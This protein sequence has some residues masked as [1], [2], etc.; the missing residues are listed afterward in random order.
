MIL[1]ITLNPVV[2]MTFYVDELAPV[3]R[4]EARRTTHVAG[5]KGNNAARALIGLGHEVRALLPLGGA[6]GRHEAELLAQ[7]GIQ[8]AIAWTSGET[9]IVVTLIDKQHQMRAYFA[10]GAPFTADDAT[11]VRERFD[12][13][14]AENITAMCLCGSSPGPLADNLY[15]EFLKTAAARGIPTLLD[16]YG[17][18]LELSLQAP[19]TIVKVNHAEAETLLGRSLSTQSAQL[20]ALEVLRAGGARW[21]VLTLGEE[22]ALLGA[23]GIQ[24]LARPPRIEALN[25]IG[26]GDAMTAGLLAG[27]VRGEP[28]EA[29]LRLGMA[30]AVA[31]ALHWDAGRI[32]TADVQ[33]LLPRI[34]ITR[35]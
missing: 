2:D 30:S 31:S 32:T 20:D 24:W 4:T 12:D 1:C 25:P 16:T 15:L 7:D 22:G 9:R 14:L 27:L 3:Y 35:L 8:T 34:E 10:P 23:A 28:A 18:A 19:P 26:S 33:P 6:S 5:G 29:C 17:E 21:S 11:R 13:A